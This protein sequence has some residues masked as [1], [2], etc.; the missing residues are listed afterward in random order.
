MNPLKFLRQWM[1]PGTTS[2]EVQDRLLA[3]RIVLIGSPI[4]DKSATETIAK[5]LFLHDRNPGL[6]ITLY[7]NSPGGKV[8][9]GLAILDTMDR[10][11]PDV[12]TLCLGRA[13]AL[14]AQIVAHGARGHRSALSSSMFSLCPIW[15]GPEGS[16]PSEIQQ[17]E[18]ARLQAI[19]VGMLAHDTG[20]PEKTV[21]AD[22]Q[23][24]MFFS[25]Y[26]ALEYGLVDA[27]IE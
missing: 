24:G 25:A 12:Y 4:D 18:I 17:E 2:G 11:T 20:W 19:L 1:C 3:D 7:I 23:S 13:D 14:A 21:H 10:I 9:A 6:P 26:E 27:V 16:S 22:F 5:L 8:T 15:S